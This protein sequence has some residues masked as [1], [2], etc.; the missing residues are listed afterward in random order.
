M[1]FVET[2]NTSLTP[3]TKVKLYPGV[4]FTPG[5]GSSTISGDLTL[6]K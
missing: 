5:K 2:L 6:R 3:Y 4:K 1:D